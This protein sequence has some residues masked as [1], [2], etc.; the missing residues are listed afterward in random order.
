MQK[1]S[2]AD[3][4]IALTDEY[5]EYIQ[6]DYKMVPNV[7]KNSKTGET[8]LEKE[9]MRQPEAALISELILKLGFNSRQDFDDYEYNGEFGWAVKRARL[10][11]EAEYERRLHQQAPTGAIFALK[12]LGWNEK[13]PHPAQLDE[14]ST[15]LR[16][17][18]I[19][20]GLQLANNEK[21]VI[22]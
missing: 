22:L 4:I 18:I 16:I 12:S 6:G 17:E 15:K 7:A 5:F 13:Q 2:T 21:D 10:R 14:T 9:W 20:T 1:L 11:I 8:T 19:H 3:E